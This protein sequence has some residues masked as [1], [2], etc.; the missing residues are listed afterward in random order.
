MTSEILVKQLKALG[1]PTRL[2]LAVRLQSGEFGAQELQAALGISQPNL[3]RHL[4]VLREAGVIEERRDGR[5]AYYSLVTNPLTRSVIDLS[6]SAGPRPGVSEKHIHKSE[7][8]SLP[9]PTKD[10]SFEEWLL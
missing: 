5:N 1:E 8:K 6:G 7:S 9:E 3:S 2:D 10:S 4:K